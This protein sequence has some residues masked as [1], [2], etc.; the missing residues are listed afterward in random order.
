MA[1]QGFVNFNSL[2][3][4]AHLIPATLKIMQ[5]IINIV[6]L[7]V[8]CHMSETLAQRALRLDR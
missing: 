2:N 7:T 5:N 4:K 8:I 6:I 3:A 1:G